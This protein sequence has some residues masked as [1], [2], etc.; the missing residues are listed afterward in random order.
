MLRRHGKLLQWTMFR[1]FDVQNGFAHFSATMNSS[2]A[3]LYA[4]RTDVSPLSRHQENIESSK[5]FNELLKSYINNKNVACRGCSWL[6]KKVKSERE[7]I[8]S[9]GHTCLLSNGHYSS[10]QLQNNNRTI[11]DTKRPHEK[12]LIFFKTL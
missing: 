11:H 7:K 6:K 1:K 5:I 3:V 2:E 9:K 8:I 4:K 10:N 12:K